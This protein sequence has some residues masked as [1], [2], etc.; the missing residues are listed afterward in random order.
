[1]SDKSNFLVDYTTLQQLLGGLGDG[2][3]MTDIN[4]RIVFMNKMAMDLFEYEFLPDTDVNVNDIIRLENIETKEKIISPIICAMRTKRSQGLSK[5]IGFIR[6]DG[7]V[8]LSATCSPMINPEGT[9]T[10]CTAIFRNVT[11]MRML[12]RK[13]ESDH[14]Y[15]RLVFE[16]AKIGICT[17]NV[18]GEITEINEPAL[19]TLQEE[20]SN[21]LGK[22]FGDAIHCINSLSFGCGKSDRCKFC[23]IRNNIDAAILDDSF[24]VDFVVAVQT[25][26]SEEP[27]WLQMFLMQIWN[28]NKK[29]IVLTLLNISK[30]KQREHELQ[31]ARYHAEVASNTKTQFLANMSHEIR[32]PINGMSGMI[33][34]TLRTKLTDEQRE[35]LNAA[36]Q[37]SDDLLRII[38]DILDY[39]K[40][41]NGKMILE[42]IDIDFHELLNRVCSLHGQMAENKGLYFNQPQ[43]DDLPHFVRG[44]PLRIR[45]ILHNLLSNAVKFTMDGG[46]SLGVSIFKSSTQEY[47]EFYVEDT[48]IGMSMDEQAK[49]FKPFSQ[50]DGSTTRRFGGTGLGLMIVKELVA[51]MGGEISVSSRQGKGSRFTFI[52]P[53]VL[54]QKADVELKNRAV[55]MNPYKITRDNNNGVTVTPDDYPDEDI[56]DLLKYCEGKLNDQEGNL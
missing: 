45:Q 7:A 21:V 36:K 33:D 31:E 26:F 39:S 43:I 38:N 18:R 20:Y 40:L 30:R 53:L 6:S 15:M 5:N 54:A 25:K 8:Y 46:I 19:E 56:S 55:F 10:G 27:I 42:N 49:L 14:Y 37:C 9:V 41:E 29:Q 48:G 12:E 51:S 34:L 35:N 47:L 22:Q 32:T 44:D 24:T 17:L 11:R 16:A 3:V 13:V 23:V 50:I 4:G 1:M 52:I 28:G 2:F